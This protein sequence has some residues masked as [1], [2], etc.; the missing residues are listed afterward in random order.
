MLRMKY[1]RIYMAFII[2]MVASLNCGNAPEDTPPWRTTEELQEASRFACDGTPYL[3]VTGE[4]TNQGT[5][6]FGTRS[7]EYI[8]KIR[9]NDPEHAINFYIFQHDKDGYART[10]KSRWMGRTLLEF[11]QEATWPASIYIYTDPDADG[12]LMSI[13]EKIA[14]VYNLPE[15]AQLQQDEEF[16]EQI[17]YPVE[18]VCPME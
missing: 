8:L 5:N 3:I 9:N 15:C 2:L 16:F 12:P 4:I 13:P 17:S 11:G 10:E 7:C 18:S 14:G 6:Q 1:S